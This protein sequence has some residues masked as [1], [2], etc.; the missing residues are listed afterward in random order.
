MQWL[1]TAYI[2]R[3]V[4]NDL[5]VFQVFVPRNASRFSYTPLKIGFEAAIAFAICTTQAVASYICYIQYVNL[6]HSSLSF[7]VFTMPPRS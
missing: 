3:F 1:P 2:I 7:Q 6:S 4:L 5:S